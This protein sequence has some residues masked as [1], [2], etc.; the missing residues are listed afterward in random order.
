MRILTELEKAKTERGGCKMKVTDTE[1]EKAL[2]RHVYGLISSYRNNDD[3]K[4]KEHGYAVAKAFDKANKVDIGS[5]IMGLVSGNNLWQTQDV[6][7]TMDKLAELFQKAQKYRISRYKPGEYIEVMW[8][9]QANRYMTLIN[10]TGIGFGGI[11]LDT[12]KEAEKVAN[13]IEDELNRFFT[14]GD[15][16]RKI[17]LLWNKISDAPLKGAKE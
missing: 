17:E 14:I 11:K 15:Y 9:E 12:S 4:F 1:L 13:E 6:K 16:T 7:P 2:T 5:Q 10:A 8:V 3:A